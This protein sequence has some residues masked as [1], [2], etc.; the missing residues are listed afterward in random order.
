MCYTEKATWARH[1]HERHKPRNPQKHERANHEL[2]L[3]NNPRT[4]LTSVGGNMCMHDVRTS[5]HVWQEELCTRATCGSARSQRQSW[6][7][8]LSRFFHCGNHLMISCHSEWTH[9]LVPCVATGCLCSFLGDAGRE[10]PSL[11]VKHAFLMALTKVQGNCSKSDPILALG[12]P[13]DQMMADIPLKPHQCVLLTD[14]TLLVVRSSQR[15][16]LIDNLFVKLTR[17]IVNPRM[18][19]IYVASSRVLVTGPVST[20]PQGQGGVF[21][22]NT[23]FDTTPGRSSIGIYCDPLSIGAVYIDGASHQTSAS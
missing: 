18:P 6:G 3:P 7:C 19:F 4:A 9:R 14:S 2:P 17:R 1:H 16:L 21:I 8:V 11:R 22:T 10:V 13:E 12:L 5:E 20:T 23:T 15:K